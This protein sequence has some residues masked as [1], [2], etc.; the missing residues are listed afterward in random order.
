M[1]DYLKLEY[2]GDWDPLR[3][4]PELEKSVESRTEDEGRAA[5]ETFIDRCVASRRLRLY[6]ISSHRPEWLEV[7]APA[8]S[9]RAS[10]RGV[11]DLEAGFGL[12]LRLI[13]PREVD[14]SPRNAL[15][16]VLSG[17]EELIQYGLSHF[18]AKD[19]ALH[20]L[21]CKEVAD[22]Y[23]KEGIRLMAITSDDYRSEAREMLLAEATP[24]ERLKGLDPEQRL[25]G[26]DP[27]Q[28]L[29]GLGPEERLKGL[30]PEQRLK[31]LD[32]EQAL[33]I[34]F[35]EASDEQIRAMLRQAGS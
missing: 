26:L 9:A 17:N 18:Q 34:L 16:N 19:R 1:V 28:R 2:R 11:Y 21:F 23:S 13:I 6:C 27:E 22:C 10:A 32:R 14:R 24:E 4:S 29:R 3:A 12:P 31:G 30:D 15:W 8:L 20:S 33:R 7:P 25:K 35:P 5:R